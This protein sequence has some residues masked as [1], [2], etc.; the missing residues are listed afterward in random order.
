MKANGE[1]ITDM[2]I[3]ETVLITETSSYEYIVAT[4]EESKDLATMILDGLMGSIM[5]HEQRTG[6]K[7]KTENWRSIAKLTFNKQVDPV[8]ND[9]DSRTKGQTHKYDKKMVA[10]IDK[11]ERKQMTQ[12]GIPVKEIFSPNAETKPWIE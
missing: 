7:I 1:S 2:Q 10:R 6:R 12:T 9:D 8:K 3:I 11:I 4:I 5:A